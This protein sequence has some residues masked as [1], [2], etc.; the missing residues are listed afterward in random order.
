MYIIWTGF[1]CYAVNIS[2]KVST[3][4]TFVVVWISKRL[5]KCDFQI[6]GLSKNAYQVNNRLNVFLM[7]KSAYMF[8]P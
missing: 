8:Q 7:E 6:N 4:N 3:W 5:Y 1:K 2:D